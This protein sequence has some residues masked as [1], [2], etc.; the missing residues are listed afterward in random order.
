MKPFTDQ[1]RADLAANVLGLLEE[2]GKQMLTDDMTEG[3]TWLLS[4]P[5][6]HPAVT[7]GVIMARIAV[8]AA[9]RREEGGQA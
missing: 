8:L 5:A 2:S 7:L 9:M 6:N 4:R 3:A 1:E